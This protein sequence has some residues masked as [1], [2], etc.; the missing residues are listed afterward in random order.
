LRG[1]LSCIG[2]SADSAFAVT[3]SLVGSNFAQTDEL[4]DFDATSVTRTGEAASPHIV[5]A[6]GPSGKRDA[7]DVLYMLVV[8]GA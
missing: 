3:L 5:G 6:R 8:C 2:V 7:S 1:Q 4:K